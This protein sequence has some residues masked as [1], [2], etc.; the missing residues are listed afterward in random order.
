MASSNLPPFILVQV[1]E[2]APQFEAFS[3]ITRNGSDYILYRDANGSQAT[4]SLRSDIIPP[5]GF[6]LADGFTHPDLTLF[7]TAIGEGFTGFT[8]YE[9]QEYLDNL[10]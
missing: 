3:K 8:R 5:P 7:E 6:T 4:M 9:A 2:T 1:G 10:P